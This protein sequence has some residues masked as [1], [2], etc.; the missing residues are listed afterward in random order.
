MFPDIT[1]NLQKQHA[2]KTKSPH[3]QW[4]YQATVE[5]CLT[6]NQTM[7][8]YTNEIQSIQQTIKYTIYSMITWLFTKCTSMTPPLLDAC[9]WSTYQHH[10]GYT[11][12]STAA[13]NNRS[14]PY[15]QARLYWQETSYI[16]ALSSTVENLG[17]YDDTI[18][19]YRP[20]QSCANCTLNHLLAV[21]YTL[22]RT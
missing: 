10:I 11:Y 15:W 17:I 3:V 4:P 22:D 18:L 1:K 5:Q 13:K 12:S 14:S 21:Q 16:D 8:T 9:P 2:K 19:A 6:T 20:G 7:L